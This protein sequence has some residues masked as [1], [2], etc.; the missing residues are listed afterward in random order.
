MAVELRHIMT[1]PVN[2]GDILKGSYGEWITL[3]L[4]CILFIAVAGAVLPKH[5]TEKRYGKAITIILGI[6]LGLGLYI[7]KDV[8]HF[9]FESFGFMA[10]WI[11][12]ILAFM[13]LFG[14]FKMGTRKDLAIAATYCIMF[15]SFSL[16]T[17]SL[18]DAISESFPLINLVFIGAFAYLLI[19]LI[20]AMIGKKPSFDKA[21]ELMSSLRKPEINDSKSESKNESEIDQ[22]IK[23]DKKEQKL[24]K[25]KTRKLTK[26]EI[27][28]VDDIE[29]AVEGMVKL[30]NERGNDVNK[31]EIDELKRALRQIAQKEEI[32][33][34]G[35]N[36]ITDH[37]KA[38]K[39]LHR[40]DSKELQERLSKTNERKKKRTI[41]EEIHYQ[42]RMLQALDFMDRY[43]PKIEQFARNLNR[44]IFEAM[45][46]VNQ[47]N[48]KDAESYLNHARTEL[49]G[50]RHI[51]QKQKELE[52]YLLKINKKTIRDLKKERKSAQQR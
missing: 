13:L 31:D 27:K 36:L 6:I 32:L 20:I 3:A 30:V 52:N 2:P 34:R 48:P 17:P 8:F 44:L 25:H 12:L 4:F 38:F 50:I 33:K 29:D 23:D 43:G 10:I 47:G 16:L 39:T 18:F 14:L 19:K 7:T 5:L 9:N 28:T 24:I 26:E 49:A 1:S 22:D 45:Q 51:Y 42:E 11:I 46:K 21:H 40:K 15:L 37:I 35:L 41:E